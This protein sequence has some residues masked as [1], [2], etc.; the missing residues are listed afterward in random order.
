MSEPTCDSCH[1]QMYEVIVEGEDGID[2]SY[3]VDCATEILGRAPDEEDIMPPPLELARGGTYANDEGGMVIEDDEGEVLDDGE[4]DEWIDEGIE[5]EHNFDVGPSPDDT[6][7]EWAEAVRDDPMYRDDPEGFRIDYDTLQRR[8]ED[9]GLSTQER[10]ETLIEWL[11]DLEEEEFEVA[12]DEGGMERYGAAAQQHLVSIRNHPMY[13]DDPDGFRTDFETLQMQWEQRGLSDE[14]R[15][16]TIREWLE[17]LEEEE[18]RFGDDEL[19]PLRGDDE[20]PIEG[21]VIEE[22][23]GDPRPR[24]VRQMAYAGLDDEGAIEGEVIEEEIVGGNGNGGQEEV[25]VLSEDN[26]AS[27]RAQWRLDHLQRLAEEEGLSEE[28]VELERRRQEQ[29][30]ALWDQLRGLQEDLRVEDYLGYNGEWDIF[31]LEDAIADRE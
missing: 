12:R 20:A 13:R 5:A 10:I 9:R 15:S 25:V 11:E 19:E 2:H 24:L 1:N 21:E 28:E 7:A 30:E 4:I 18:E 16:D 6:I 31:A 22:L 26:Y 23:R 14:Q 8:W 27:Q 3:C 29:G 17:D